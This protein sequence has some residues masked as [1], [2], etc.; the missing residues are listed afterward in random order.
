M[1]VEGTKSDDAIGARF[2]ARVIQFDFFIGD[3]DV[4]F[5]S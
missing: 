5:K 2:L 3:R 4:D 1:G